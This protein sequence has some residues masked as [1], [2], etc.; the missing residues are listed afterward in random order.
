[1]RSHVGK[2]SLTMDYRPCRLFTLLGAMAIHRKCLLSETKQT[3]KSS[4]PFNEVL[5]L[6]NFPM[7]TNNT[8][9]K[10]CLLSAGVT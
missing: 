6:R 4:R 3:T 9:G 1:M 2:A 8:V 7:L 5:I 10:G